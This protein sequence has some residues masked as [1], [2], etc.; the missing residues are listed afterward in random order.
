M[1]MDEK[2]VLV[3]LENK[4]EISRLINRENLSAVDQLAKGSQDLAQQAE[5]L[6]SVIEAFEV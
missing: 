3:Q 6:K 4:D 2:Y 1:T 5:N